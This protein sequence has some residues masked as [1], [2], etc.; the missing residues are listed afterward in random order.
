M[1]L[2]RFDTG[3]ER[4]RNPKLVGI[5]RR[6]TILLGWLAMIDKRGSM[7]ETSPYERCTRKGVQRRPDGEDHKVRRRVARA[8]HTCR[9]ALSHSGLMHFGIEA[10]SFCRAL[11]IPDISFRE[12]GDYWRQPRSDLQRPRLL[13]RCWTVCANQKPSLMKGQLD[14]VATANAPFFFAPPCVFDDGIGYLLITNRRSRFSSNTRQTC[15][16]PQP[17]PAIAFSQRGY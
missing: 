6:C 8:D 11:K 14:L 2:S 12:R 17:A 7:L 16:P 9:S 4:F 10:V 5:I 3:W 1:K 15:S 13:F